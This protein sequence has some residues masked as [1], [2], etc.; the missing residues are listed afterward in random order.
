VAAAD[1]SEGRDFLGTAHPGSAALPRS[2]T[3]TQDRDD[4]ADTP[5]RG[6]KDWNILMVTGDTA[7]VREIGTYQR[8]GTFENL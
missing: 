8:L 4:Q 2:G 1:F 7:A 3:V 5:L 6:G